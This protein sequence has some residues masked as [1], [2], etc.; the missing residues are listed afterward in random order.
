MGAGNR[1]AGVFEAGDMDVVI[2]MAYEA[3]YRSIPDGRTA[4]MG[5]SAAV[6]DPCATGEAILAA[7]RV[8][9][10]ESLKDGF[11]RLLNWALREAP[12]SEKGI[13]YHVTNAAAPDFAR[14]CFS[15]HFVICTS[16]FS[17]ML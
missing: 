6:T 17:N 8:T 9:K 3:V 10:D 5:D 13:V 1:H 11:D 4:Q 16:H 15:I 12:R 2:P 7:Y 14:A